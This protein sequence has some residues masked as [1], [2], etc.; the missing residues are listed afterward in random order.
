MDKKYNYLESPGGWLGV[1]FPNNCIL[2]E[3]AE[4]PASKGKIG[5]FRIKTEDKE[6]K[7]RPTQRMV[8][9]I[10]GIWENIWELE[11]E[12]IHNLKG[13]TW[14]EISIMFI[15]LEMGKVGEQQRYAPT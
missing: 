1:G 13:T 5:W 8:E 3:G 11:K 7:D 4:T 6:K 9:K 14:E 2:S 10:L 12:E 15:V